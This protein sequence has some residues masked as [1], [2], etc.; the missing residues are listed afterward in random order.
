M[1]PFLFATL[2]LA[3]L[4][5]F[6]GLA[7]AA[8]P[9]QLT[10]KSIIVG[11]TENRQQKAPGEE[12]MRSVTASAQ[13]SI[14]VSAAG[15]PF[16]RLQMAIANRRGNLRSGSRDAV[17]GENSNRSFDFRGNTLTIGIPRGSSGATNIVATFDGGFQ[18]CT[19]IAM[20]GKTGGAAAIQGRSMI[21]GQRGRVD[22]YSIETTNLS[23]RVQDGNVF[24]N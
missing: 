23:C 24:G 8:A 18:S 20:S 22:M 19:A 5:G 1:R 17:S 11:W 2:F 15:R 9:K 16:S 6:N 13:F 21:G 7:Q 4:F 10:G 14:Y 12:Q 3:S